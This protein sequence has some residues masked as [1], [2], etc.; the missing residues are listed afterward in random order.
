VRWIAGV[1]ALI[2]FIGI[3]WFPAANA[4][5]WE[6]FYEISP[7]LALALGSVLP[8]R[9]VSSVLAKV[10]IAILGLVGVL[11][12]AQLSLLSVHLVDGAD[13]PGLLLQ[14]LIVLSLVSVLIRV[15]SS[16]TYAEIPTG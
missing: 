7:A 12:I 13:Y 16:R 8:S 5:S 4:S 11:R 10:C 3:T 1:F 9:I 6:K 14:I 2:S 15:L